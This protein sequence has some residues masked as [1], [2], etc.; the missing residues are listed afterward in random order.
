[1]KTPSFFHLTTLLALLALAVLPVRAQDGA[2]LKSILPPPE[3][4]TRH[5]DALNLTS[6][7]GRALREVLN[8][9]H[10]EFT[11]AESNL[12]VATRELETAVADATRP[13][14]E[15]TRKVEALLQAENRAKIVRFNASL[16]ARR[17]LTD[18]QW[19]KARTLAAAAPTRPRTGPA[20]NLPEDSRAA[21][22][23]KLDRVRA[24]AGEVFPDGPPPEMR[25]RFAALPDKVRSGQTAEA[26]KLFDQLIADLEKRRDDARRVP[27]NR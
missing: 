15:V 8:G 4:Y 22:K 6:E 10:R 23:A 5:K 27:P 14:A 11:P 2:G 16:A 1:M 9:L 13:A 3:F 17:L 21:L 26:E 25:R 12:T 18:E 19:A 24:L 7:Q 20:S